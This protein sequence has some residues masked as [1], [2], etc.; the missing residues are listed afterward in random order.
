MQTRKNAPIAEARPESAVAKRPMGEN[1]EFL[2]G[3]RGL[4]DTVPRCSSLKS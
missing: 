4:T 1:H 3:L 2:T